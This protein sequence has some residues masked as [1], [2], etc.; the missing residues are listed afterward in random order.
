MISI[1]LL[2]IIVAM[3]LLFLRHTAVYKDP[4]K[5][6][7]TPVVL[8]L[9]FISALLHLVLSPILDVNIIKESL[10]ALSVGVLL[11]A[12]MSVMNQTVSV[13]ATHEYRLRVNTIGDE[14]ATLSST[15]TTL[16]DR[17]D[18]VTQMEGSTHEQIR[19]V[20]IEEFDA[21]NTIQTNQKLFITKIEALLLQQQTSMG[22]FEEF[23][24]SE[25]PSLDSVVHRHIDMLR[26]AEQDH[27]NQLKNVIQYNFDEHKEVHVHLKDLHDLLIQ[28]SHQQSTEH[29]VAVV[30]KELDRIINDF[31]HHLQMLGAKS[32]SIITSLLE[33]DAL[34]K[35][36]REQSELI[37]QQMV[38]SS[39]QMREMTTHSKE[40]SDSM[41]PLSRLFASSESLYNEFIHA[42]G[43]LNEL[44]ITLESY[45][46][47]EY[48]AIRQSLEEVA[49][50]AIS[51]MKLLIH[52]IQT[53]ES[54]TKEALS[55]IETKNVQELASK[56]KLH[57]SYLG[58]NQE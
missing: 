25:F 20:F 52:T 11:S 21:L 58:E 27:F 45:E 35:G 28:L 1:D 17:I 39:K 47:Q 43:K 37:M 36:S 48:R 10:L 57:K 26:I 40:L 51:Q 49:A 44:I 5:I 42:K 6:N 54:H 15:I 30:Q 4:T 16:K 50:E 14:I 53:R 13:L 55:M 2:L 7:Y 3:S 31:S 19:T 46:H 34:L 41:M 29:T 18:L 23:T 56:V 32:E 24:L 8:A 33:N 38:L 22:R 12:V 9:G